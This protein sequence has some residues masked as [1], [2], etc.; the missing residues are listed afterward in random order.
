MS[1][2]VAILDGGKD[3]WGVR[4][5]DFRGCHGGGPTP[6][7]AI[8]DATSALREFAALMVADGEQ[9]PRARRLDEL[10]PDERPGHG[11]SLVMIPLILDKGRAV[12][13]SISLD[14]GLLEAID[15]EAKRRGLTRSAF[16]VS[17]AID[18][19]EGVGLTGGKLAEGGADDR[20]IGGFAEAA[21]DDKLHRRARTLKRR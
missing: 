1:Y 4:L 2:Y 13:A 10:G 16:L 6:D 9:I 15:E 21:P 8:A 7:A 3:V 20:T 12:K 19:I 17:A 18:K 14:A 5:P 11:E